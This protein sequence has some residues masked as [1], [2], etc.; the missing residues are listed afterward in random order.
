MS[1]I[2]FTGLIHKE[3]DYSIN[4]PRQA[5]SVGKAKCDIPIRIPMIQR[6]YAEGRQTSFVEGKRRNLLT[7]MLDVV[8]EAKPDL[9][10]D[11]VYGYMRDDKGICTIKNYND[12][13]AHKK[14]FFE[15]LDGQQRLTTLFLMHW[16]FGREN[17]LKDEYNHSLFVYETRDT[18]EEFCHWLVNHSSKQIIDNWQNNITDIAKRN[19]DNKDKWDTEKDSEGKIDKYLNMLKYPIQAK[20]SLLDYMKS[21]D[22][23]KWAWREDPSIISMIV[24]LEEMYKL[25]IERNWTYDDGIAKNQNLN[26]ITFMLLDDLECDGNELFEKM[27]ARGKALT[28]FEILKSVLEEE[29]ELQDLPY[30]N[31]KIYNDWRNY[32][33]GKWV[34]YCWQNTNL[35]EKPNLK[36]VKKVETKLEVLLLRMISKS[37]FNQQIISTT[38][39]TQDAV[40]FGQR[41]QNCIT[42]S[43]DNV[44]NYYVDYAR[45]ERSL[46]S[47]NGISILD[48]K[49]VSEDINNLLYSSKDSK[50]NIVWK[51]MTMY[52]HEKGIYIH[53]DNKN[54]LMDD[55][56]GN[57]THYTRVM[58]YALTKYLG[59]VHGGAIAGDFSNG[60]SE[61]EIESVNFIDWMRFIRN[62]YLMDNK[63][64]RLD[65]VSDVNSA[66]DA[67]DN[68][69]KVFFDKH[70]KRISKNE[71]LEFI[72]DYIV[73]NPL[74]QEQDR[75][76]EEALKAELRLRSI[77]WDNAIKSAEENYYLW[78]QIIAPLSWSEDS[79]GNY[80]VNKFN[81]YMSKFNVIFDK[82]NRLDGKVVDALLT[83]AMLC[84]N[85]IRAMSN[86][87]GLGS[88]RRF[89]NHRDYSWKRYLRDKVNGTY[90]YAFKQ[91]I[92]NWMLSENNAK[93]LEV[94]LKDFITKE[95]AQ[96]P[97]TDWRFYIVNLEA[98]E[99]LE[100][101]YFVQSSTRHIYVNP[102][103]CAYYF[104]SQ[105]MRTTIRY[106]LITIYLSKIQR[107]YV[108]GVRH[109]NVGH[110]YG[111]DGAYVE[112]ELP[113]ND[114]VRVK[115]IGDGF[116]DVIKN[117]N[118]ISSK[119]NI[120][121]LNNYLVDNNIIIS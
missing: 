22:D 100:A 64:A 117:G 35:G 51:D 53:N 4:I 105:T 62:V 25:I 92:D 63:T 54:T 68:W 70:S 19:K 56:T 79:T 97:N 45:Y 37:F 10:F 5:P 113:N 73:K 60:I 65:N 110:F 15:P 101:L 44:V 52:L 29:M 8:Y 86:T 14:A 31:N 108:S 83:Q 95:K 39:T 71:M 1:K 81:A 111:E 49:K 26:K 23:F 30:S 12:Y 18:S 120:S 32:V 102:S 99:L 24:V 27:N 11:F 84:V 38:P 77:D 87:Q 107:L 57:V 96:I 48:F 85:D 82:Y 17:E 6:D 94:F 78:G 98:N 40:N 16:F 50:E 69:L 2:Y 9:S 75:L 89:N 112:F 21:L 118:V 61:N 74:K 80:N 47:S 33:D 67:I 66:I 115:S 91:L 20:P 90:G 55:F 104:R 72:K 88:L 103:G 121:G 93:S 46:S 42:N 109:K 119:I 41:L 7:D 76:I 34:D 58:F 106:E 13:E 43:P 116:Y 59:Y 3:L 36:D 114:I 28:N